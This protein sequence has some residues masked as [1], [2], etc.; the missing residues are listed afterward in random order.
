MSKQTPSARLREA[1]QKFNFRLASKLAALIVLFYAVFCLL[2]LYDLHL[3]AVILYTAVALGAAIYY[4]V[5]NRGVLSG[6]VTPEMLPADWSDEQKQ[7][8][9][10]DMTARRQKSKWVQLILI[11]MVFVYAFELLEFYFFPLLRSI[12]GM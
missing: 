6:K 2:K 12:L 10:D 7:A 1:L 4:V 8:F 3:F 11:P 5:Y 9:I